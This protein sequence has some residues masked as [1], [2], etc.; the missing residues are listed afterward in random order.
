MTCCFGSP[1]RWD[2]KSAEL[3]ES[4]CNRHRGVLHE[5]CR[6]NE[7]SRVVCAGDIP[8]SSAG[9][10]DIFIGSI[11]MGILV[12]CSNH[13]PLWRV[14]VRGKWFAFCPTCASSFVRPWVTMD[15]GGSRSK[16]KHTRLPLTFSFQGLWI[17]YKVCGLL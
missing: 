7:D 11:K 9:H 12:S 17:H 5:N 16:I 15:H 8:P 13:L 2:M 4:T 10:L 1:S 6:R 3:P 14:S